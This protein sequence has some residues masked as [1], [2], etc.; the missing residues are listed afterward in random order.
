MNHLQMQLAHLGRQA[1]ED[2][3]ARR[4]RE[5][6][7]LSVAES[8]DILGVPAATLSRWE[9]GLVVPSPWHA[10]SLAA[11]LSLWTQELQTTDNE[12][13]GV[14]AH[15]EAAPYGRPCSRG[16]GDGPP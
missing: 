8:A 3:R 14:P 11:L 9:R 5:G 4:L 13:P 16:D 10:L 2:G 7:G 15:K 12:A 1:C 6:R